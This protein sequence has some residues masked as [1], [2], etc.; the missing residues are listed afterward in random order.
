M[1]P[2]RPKND[3]S[4]H[5][6]DFREARRRKM[7]S[8]EGAGAREVEAGFLK[9]GAANEAYAGVESQCYDEPTSTSALRL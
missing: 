1:H 8:T 6:F 5:H 4:A 9:R 2:N 7:K 3:A